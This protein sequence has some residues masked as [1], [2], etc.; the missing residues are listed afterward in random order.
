MRFFEYVQDQGWLFPPSLRELIREDE[1]CAVINDVV[2]RIGVQ[3]IEYKYVE[4]GH[5]AYHP[6]M[7]IKIYFYAYARGIRSPRKIAQELEG[8]VKFWYLSGRQTPD[9]RTISDFR[10]NHIEEIKLLFKKVVRLCVEM[11]MV[12]LGLV[13]ID[14]T[15][16][17]ANASDKQSKTEEGLEKELKKAEEDISRF[18]DEAEKVDCGEDKKYGADKRGDEVPKELAKAAKRKAK[19]EKALKKIEEEALDKVN[20]TDNDAKI[21]KSK[22]RY[23]EPAYNCQ[24]AVDEGRGVIIAAEVSQ[25]TGDENLLQEVAEAAKNNTGNKPEK[26]VA[27]CGYY[28]TDNIEYLENKEIDGY[29][30]DTTIRKI[31]KEEKGTAEAKA[32]SKGAFYY[33]PDRDCCI[34]PERKE[35][36]LISSK[37]T[38]GRGKGKAA[39]A[40]RALGVECQRCKHFGIC[41]KSKSGRMIKRDGKEEIRRKVGKD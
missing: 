33:D 22:K 30:P 19:I 23:Y 11:G 8:N 35:L 15:K 24:T 27:D 20:V 13:A 12:N 14:G 10:K 40:Y 6:K 16:I 4:E 41:T 3:E 36:K 32:F 39:K 21:M 38:T 17:K 28:S 37:A 25:K 34:C 9:F 1:L 29:L 26:V 2:E 18:L 7:M 31:K 5:P